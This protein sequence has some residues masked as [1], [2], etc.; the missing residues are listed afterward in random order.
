[1]HSSVFPRV[2]FWYYL[3]SLVIEP[4]KQEG[5]TQVP[6]SR[7]KLYTQEAERR[8]GE[9]K[10]ETCCSKNMHLPRRGPMALHPFLAV[11]FIFVHIVTVIET[12]LS[13]K[14]AGFSPSLPHAQVRS[15]GWLILQALRI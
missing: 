8:R 7:S 1:M 12:R 10:L 4:R 13:L 5:H 9:E 15:V 6:Y 2:W 11:S 3:K 14:K